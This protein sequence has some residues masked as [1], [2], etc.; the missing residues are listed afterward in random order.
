[1][2]KFCQLDINLNISEKKNINLRLAKV[3]LTCGHVGTI[4]L[5][6]DCY[7]KAKTTV[8]NTTVK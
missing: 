2:V 3:R 1:M 8:G 4:L 7:E 6:V 5:I